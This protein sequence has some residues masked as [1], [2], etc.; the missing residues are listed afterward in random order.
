MRKI[1]ASLASLLAI[2]C[3]GSAFA[4][5]GS[6][7]GSDRQG[8]AGDEAAGRWFATAQVGT[9]GAGLSVGRF[10]AP[11]ISIRGNL[12]GG[13]DYDDSFT[14]NSRNNSLRYDAE[15]SLSSFGLLADYH[16]RN[17]FRL[18]GGVY[19]NDNKI[20]AVADFDRIRVNG[21]T[22]SAANLAQADAR[23]DFRSFAPYLGIGYHATKP[24]GWS[25]TAD[26]GV[27]YQGSP[28]VNYRLNCTSAICELA[29]PALVAEIEEER[30]ALEDEV[31]D[32]KFY[33]VLSIGL[34]YR[35]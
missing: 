20:D 23:I 6:V 4:A 35:F 31:S 15:L 32:F 19:Y 16:F 24:K 27:L 11:N 26:L 14:T 7:P 8:G 21:V 29:R 2:C 13:F 17:G 34:S 10:I 3:T 33:P 1:P 18:T 30:R 25:F 28:R 9:L 5:A 22:F 12:N